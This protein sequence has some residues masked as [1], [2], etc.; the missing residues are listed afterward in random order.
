MRIQWSRRC[1]P[2]SIHVSGLPY[3]LNG[4]HKAVKHTWFT[5]TCTGFFLC[6][7]GDAMGFIC[8][9]TDLGS[10]DIYGYYEAHAPIITEGILP[11]ARSYFEKAHGREYTD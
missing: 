6:E 1:D 7:R 3:G 11:Q 9:G 2:N 10:A 4:I 8:G 5:C